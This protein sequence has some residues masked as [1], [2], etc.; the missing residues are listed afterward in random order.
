MVTDVMEKL[1][2]KHTGKKSAVRQSSLAL[3]KDLCGYRYNSRRARKLVQIPRGVL[4]RA[5]MIPGGGRGGGRDETDAGPDD[6][7]EIEPPAVKKMAVVD[8][9][10]EQYKD[11]LE[12]LADS[13]DP[14]EVSAIENEIRELGYEPNVV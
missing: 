1:V 12:R 2:Y 9:E 11:A 13:R 8:K 5:D 3:L 10:E 4:R 7:G 6:G 14:E